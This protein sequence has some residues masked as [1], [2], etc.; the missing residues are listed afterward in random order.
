MHNICAYTQEYMY[1]IHGHSF[2]Q[3]NYWVPTICNI[4]LQELDEKGEQDWQ[5]RSLLSWREREK[6]EN[7][8][9]I[10]KWIR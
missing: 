6:I 9:E 8:H 3:W 4:L 1:L 7:K 2:I 5:A 10:Y